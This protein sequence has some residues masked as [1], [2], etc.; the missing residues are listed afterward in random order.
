MANS[1]DPDQT[2]Q[3]E[4]F[5]QGL[6]CLQ[7]IEPCFSRSIQITIPDI[8]RIVIRLFQCMVCGV[9]WDGAGRGGKSLFSLDW[10]F[11]PLEVYIIRIGLF[12]NVVCKYF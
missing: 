10:A 7:I 9:G 5:D 2:P 1:A 6:H 4:A 3:N 12:P 8:P 11:K